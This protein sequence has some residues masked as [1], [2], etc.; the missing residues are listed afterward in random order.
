M[1]EINGLRGNITAI[2]PGVD[3]TV[4]INSTT[5]STWTSGGV[6]NTRP[7]TG[8]LVYAGCE[9]DLP[10]R[11][12]SRIDVAHVGAEVRE[13]GSIDIIELVVP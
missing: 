10:C 2:T 3:I 12:N 6:L 8:E 11:F 7:Q 13:A 4:S 5:F 9:F 1:I